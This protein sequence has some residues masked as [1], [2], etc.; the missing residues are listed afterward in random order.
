MRGRTR[1]RRADRRTL[2]GV[3][4]I[5]FAVAT[6]VLVPGVGLADELLIPLGAYLILGGR[7]GGKSGR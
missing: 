2:L 7:G 1:T 6:T 5:A 3:A 4:L